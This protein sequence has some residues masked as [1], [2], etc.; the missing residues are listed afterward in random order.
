MSFKIKLVMLDSLVFLNEQPLCFFCFRLFNAHLKRL[1]CPNSLACVFYQSMKNFSF[2]T[3]C[4]NT[5][6]KFDHE[7]FCGFGAP[8]FVVFVF[9]IY[10]SRYLIYKIKKCF[11]IEHRKSISNK[12]WL[13]LGIKV[14]AFVRAN[15]KYDC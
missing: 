6:N 3:P 11:I 12:F 15:T 8:F 4:W 13:F 2:C 10:S 9:I 7:W 14:K 1:K 5:F